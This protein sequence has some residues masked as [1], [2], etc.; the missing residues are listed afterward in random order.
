MKEATMPARK[1]A[2]AT[3]HTGL[4]LFGHSEAEE[5]L[6]GQPARVYDNQGSGLSEESGENYNEAHGRE[7]K[8]PTSGGDRQAAYEALLSKK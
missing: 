4:S 3:D 5:A 7:S 8:A 1:S 2:P 6:D